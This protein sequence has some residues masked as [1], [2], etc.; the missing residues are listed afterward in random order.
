MKRLP[1]GVVGKASDYSTATASASAAQPV[2]LRALLNGR[3]LRPV[4]RIAFEGA[5]ILE[6]RRNLVVCA[7]TNSGKTLVGQALLLDAVMRGRRGVLLEPLR[8]LAQ[9]QADQLSE[10][11]G[12]LP[13]D[14]FPTTPSVVLSTGDYRLDGESM[15]AAPPAGGELIVATPERFDAVLRNPVYGAWID[16]VGA[17]VVDEAHLLADTRRGP[18]V[19]TVIASM[20][21]RSAP[22]RLALLSATLGTPERLQEWLDPCDLVLS[23]ARSPLTKEVWQLE[24]NENANDLLSHETGRLLQDPSRA[25]IVFVYRRAD[26]EVLATLL[27][28][29]MGQSALP[30]HSGQS[31]AER[32]RVRAVFQNGTCRCLV[33]TTAL[34]LGVNLPASH[35]IVRDSTFY[36]EG[37]LPIDQLLQILGRAGRGDRPGLG[38]VMIRSTDGWR[39]EEVA[40]SLKSERLPRLTSSFERSLSQ[41]HRRNN[42]ANGASVD[43]ALAGVIATALSRAGERGLTAAE[44]SQFLSHTLSGTVLASRSGDGL[45][46]LM[47]PSRALAYRTEDSRYGLTVLGAA[48]LRTMLP[49]DYL[50]GLGQLIRDLLSL[51]RHAGLLHRWSALDHLFVMALLSERTPALRRFSEDLAERLD[52]FLESRP[53]GQ[54]SLLF[55]NWVTGSAAGSKADELFGSLG[56]SAGAAP[57]TEAATARKRAYVAMLAAVVLSERSHGAGIEA[58]G[59]RWSISIGEGAEEGWRDTALWLLA[60]HAQVSDLRCFYHHLREADATPAQTHAVKTALRTL[61]LQSYEL[62]QRIKYCSPLGPLVKGIRTSRGSTGKPQVGAGT[63]ATL[64]AAGIKTMN[65]VAALDVEQLVALGVQKRFAQQIRAYVRRRQ[66]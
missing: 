8:A 27:S 36:G 22:P 31:E 34:A 30:Y 26:T 19:E 13:T 42:L 24:P 58:L 5:R 32:A 11:V 49:L 20:L 29:E 4:Q 12:S 6:T 39:P 21:S 15:G 37:R 54:K 59:Q 3:A 25:V 44:I 14:L 43:G 10:L 38:A 66:R 55:A 41:H 52:A 17:V 50:A 56:L 16:S 57:G 23:S 53:T 51:D 62:V 33:S 47:E 28:A 45:R 7:P 1:A 61:R 9:E 60:G 48:G 2:L 35:V 64:E 40:E 46:W 63:I 18:T 65:Q